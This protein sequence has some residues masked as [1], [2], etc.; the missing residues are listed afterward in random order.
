[1]TV[2]GA[3]ACAWFRVYRIAPLPPSTPLRK[4]IGTVATR[5]RSI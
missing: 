5:T 4:N 1:M 2:A 3:R